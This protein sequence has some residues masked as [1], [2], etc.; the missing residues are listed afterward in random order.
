MISDK[1]FNIEMIKEEVS[2]LITRICIDRRMCAQAEFD[3][4]ELDLFITEEMRRKMKKY[5]EMPLS[6]FLME[7]IEDVKDFEDWKDNLKNE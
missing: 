7:L 5:D 6:T 1:L 2:K 3:V 4:E